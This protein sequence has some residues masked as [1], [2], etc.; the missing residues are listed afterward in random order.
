MMS[1]RAFFYLAV[2]VF[3][4]GVVILALGANAGSPV[5][6][7]I[8]IVVLIVAVGVLLYWLLRRRQAT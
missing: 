8:G 6:T 7:L 2:L 5:V 4:I 3:L 1:S